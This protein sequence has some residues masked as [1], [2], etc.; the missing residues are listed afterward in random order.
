MNTAITLP[1]RNAVRYA[2][3]ADDEIAVTDGA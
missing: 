2:T 3:F 1:N